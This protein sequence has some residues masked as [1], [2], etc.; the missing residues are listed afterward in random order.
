MTYLAKR[1]NIANPPLVQFPESVIA[2]INH[3]TP[4]RFY[5][6]GFD[7]CTSKIDK[8]NYLTSCLPDLKNELLPFEYIHTGSVRVREFCS[9]IEKIDIDLNNP[10]LAKAV[11]VLINKALELR[12]PAFEQIY[13]SVVNDTIDHSN[14]LP[15]LQPLGAFKEL[16]QWID[17][18]VNA[19]SY[20]EAK[21]AAEHFLNLYDKLAEHFPRKNRFGSAIEH[22][23]N[24][25]RINPDLL[26]HESQR[27]LASNIGDY[28]V[29]QG[30]NK[31]YLP[32]RNHETR[33]LQRQ[34]FELNLEKST[35]PWIA[36][37]QWAGK[38]TAKLSLICCGAS[39]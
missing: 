35:H 23:N 10:E 26:P 24:Y 21:D 38:T 7:Q 34:E 39:V 14:S 27:F 19:S 4:Q 3:I 15:N 25:K 20:R 22:L 32:P 6:H 5:S 16:Q 9:L 36:H 13:L 33:E 12:I 37:L 17:V 1:D 2:E 30:F 29:W 31:P 18:F 11:D 28:I 8:I